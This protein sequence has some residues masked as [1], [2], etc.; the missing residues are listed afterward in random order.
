[1]SEPFGRPN[2]ED[3]RK[4]LKLYSD[5]ILYWATNVAVEALKRMDSNDFDVRESQFREWI[6]LTRRML[7]NYGACQILGWVLKL[8]EENADEYWSNWTPPETKQEKKT[9]VFRSWKSG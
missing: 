9:K 5:P 3:M 6:F 8:N 1:M 2:K 4:A 7:W